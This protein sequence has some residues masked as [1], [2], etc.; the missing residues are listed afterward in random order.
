MQ[1]GVIETLFEMLDGHLKYQGYLAMGGQ[2]I[3]ASIMAV[4]KQRNSNWTASLRGWDN[5]PSRR[6]PWHGL[7]AEI[8]EL[9]RGKLPE[10]PVPA[11]PQTDTARLPNHPLSIRE[12]LEV[13]I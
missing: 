11:W 6:S 2:I 12:F 9:E 13:L 5:T 4:H 1:A 10:I 3:D 8:A 7:E